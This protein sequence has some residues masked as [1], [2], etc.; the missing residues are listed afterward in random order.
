[1]QSNIYIISGGTEKTF[2]KYC[3]Y[4]VYIQVLS[5][6][7]YWKEV[8]CGYFIIIEYKFI[9]LHQL[10]IYCNLAPNYDLLEAH[11]NLIQCLK[12]LR[13]I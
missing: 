13:T 5:E 4:T 1:M 8:V 12:I 3:N 2:T 11:S 10:F 6:F 7:I 9:I